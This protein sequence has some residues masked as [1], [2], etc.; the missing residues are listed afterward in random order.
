MTDIFIA[1]ILALCGLALVLLL[2]ASLLSGIPGI[3]NRMLRL[4]FFSREQ[5]LLAYKRFHLQK[6]NALLGQER[7][8]SHVLV[9]N[10]LYRS[11]PIFRS[12]PSQEFLQVLDTYQG[13]WLS[14]AIACLRK[15]QSPALGLSRLEALL[16]LQQHTL[17]A[18]RDSEDAWRE[19]Q[20]KRGKDGKAL[21]AWAKG[22][23]MKKLAI[24]QE[25]LRKNRFEIFQAFHEFAKN[26]GHSKSPQS[27]SGSQDGYIQ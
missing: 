19:I 23:Q 2:L 15:F 6:V 7:L 26:I 9:K 14:T 21:P 22:E 13:A 4:P 27:S 8:S 10:S 1:G 3:R 5:F 24:L 18:L 17:R 25:K 11:L 20:K 16:R 12:V